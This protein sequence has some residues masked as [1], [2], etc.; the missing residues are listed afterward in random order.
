M[1]C[2]AS[3]KPRNKKMQY[4]KSGNSKTYEEQL[5]VSQSTGNKNNDKNIDDIDKL[6]GVIFRKSV[7]EYPIF[8]YLS[9]GK[10]FFHLVEHK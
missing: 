3:G 4:W 1:Y 6:I 2:T 10:L 5:T 9:E 7:N 8:F